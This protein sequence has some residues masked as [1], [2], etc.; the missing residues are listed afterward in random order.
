MKTLIAVLFFVSAQAQAAQVVTHFVKGDTTV[1]GFYDSTF[2]YD[3]AEELPTTTFCYKGD[4]QD[5][6]N[7]VQKD[8]ADMSEAYRQGGHD[9]LNLHSCH[10]HDSVV[11]VNYEIGDD[12]G[13]Y[14]PNIVRTI[15]A[16]Q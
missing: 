16:C 14:L 6:C 12:Y 7:Q 2:M 5:V 3:H 4:L 8:A 11:F 1:E 10:T 9:Y 15:S 13:W